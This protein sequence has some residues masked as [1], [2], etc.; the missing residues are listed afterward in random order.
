MASVNLNGTG[1][2]I[3]FGTLT[4]AIISDRARPLTQLQTKSADYSSRSG[5]LKQLNGKLAALT[6]AAAALTDRDL[7]TGRQA[8]STA[9]VVTSATST[10]TAVAGTA[11]LSVTR[12]ATSL[13]QA[14]R[15]YGDDKGAV[16]AGAA[17]TATF[18]LRKGGA[19]T[20][21]PI[22]I[23]A[24]NN[25]L[26][27]LRDAINAAD[28]GVTAAIVDVDGT[29]TQFK[30]VMNSSA[31]GVSGRV[32]LV[33][34]TAVDTGTGADLNLASLNPPGA[35]SDFSDLNAAFTINGLGLTRATNTVSD[36]IGGVTLSLKTV[37]VATITV[38]TKTSDL[39]DKIAGFVK[40]YNDVQD[41]IAGQYA[42]DG[43]GRPTGALAGD[44]TLRAAQR[45]LRDAVGGSSSDNGGALKD[46]TEIGIGRDN[47]GKLT[48]DTVVLNDKLTTS[49][50]DVRALLAGKAEGDTGIF[51]KIH[52]A[53]G[54]LSDDITGS[55]K[56]AIDGFTD[57]IKRLDK[58]IADQLGRL[59]LLRQ[60]LTRQFAVADA[61]ISQL[62]GQ[63]ST[64]TSVIDSLNS[65][66]NK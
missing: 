49:T 9:N 63:G 14:S 1:S 11:N 34:T 35:T 46:L 53:Y 12:L 61:A 60:T 40:A 20:G 13:A 2:N 26:T 55:V 23:D 28:A 21:T 36:A 24:T 10:D 37:G 6:L 38:T 27:G 31:T 48:L 4:D 17:T 52:N 5:A 65:N 15:T 43:S 47:S 18:E 39:G 7:G 25:T 66:N 32:E 57:S 59:A 3:D 56:S 42:K 29:G 22:T 50:S 54:A 30:L 64:L 8:G 16:L 44:Q 51:N 41:F 19:L 45:Q 62:N 58:N 33:E